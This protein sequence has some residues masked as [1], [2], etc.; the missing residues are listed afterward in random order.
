MRLEK[1]WET[2]WRVSFWVKEER[3]SITFD[4]NDV[5]IW[6]ILECIKQQT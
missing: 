2:L 1:G 5:S 6:E 3:V 4:I